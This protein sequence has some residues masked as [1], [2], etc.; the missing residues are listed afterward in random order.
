MMVTTLGP[1]LSCLVRICA[2]EIHVDNVNLMSH[3]IHTP[4]QHG[5]SSQVAPRRLRA[6]DA[7][8]MH[9]HPPTSLV[10]NHAATYLLL[11]CTQCP[12]NPGIRLA[13]ATSDVHIMDVRTGRWDKVTPLGEPPSPRAAHSAAA[14]GN[15]VV[16]QGGIGPAGLAHEDLYVL[17]FTDVERPRWHRYMHFHHRVFAPFLI[18]CC[19]GTK[20]HT[21]LCCQSTDTQKEKPHVLKQMV[22]HLKPHNQQQ[23]ARWSLQRGGEWTRAQCTLCARPRARGQPLFGGHGRQRRQAHAQ[24]CMV[25]GHV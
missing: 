18:S 20:Q 3:A 2:L 16:I 12:Q 15:M 8:T 25:T 19:S 13:G 22:F 6:R 24:R 9:R 5:A 21:S 14:V 4:N 23:T 7:A 11:E 10:C 17:D 1:S